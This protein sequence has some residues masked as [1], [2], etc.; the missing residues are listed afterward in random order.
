[1]KKATL[2]LALVLELLYGCSKT[3]PVYIENALIEDNENSLIT[4]YYPIPSNFILK[5]H[6]ASI[7]VDDQPFFFLLDLD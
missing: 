6:S 4:I 5:A 2:I 1:M 7:S 3:I